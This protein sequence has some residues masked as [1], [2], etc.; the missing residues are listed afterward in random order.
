LN[1]G[2][3]PH[4]RYK[5]PPFRDT[6]SALVNLGYKKNTAQ[7]FLEKAYK[8]GFNDMKPLKETLKQLTGKTNG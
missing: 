7:E 6:L 5:G 8:Q 3:I 1:S 4:D 2:K